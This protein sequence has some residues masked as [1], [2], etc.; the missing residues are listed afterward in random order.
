MANYYTHTLSLALLSEVAVA[1]QC[2]DSLPA[3]VTSTDPIVRM[4]CVSM[5]TTGAAFRHLHA[6][7]LIEC[8][9]TGAERAAA[10]AAAADCGE[11]DSAMHMTAVCGMIVHFNAALLGLPVHAC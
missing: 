4:Q 8:N 2:L 1:L 7:L 5:Y 6:S 9:S 3:A 11:G 10:A